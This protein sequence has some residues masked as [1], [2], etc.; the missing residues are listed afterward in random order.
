MMFS[1]HLN[2]V[3]FKTAIV[4]SVLNLSVVITLGTC[5]NAVRHWYMVSLSL[6]EL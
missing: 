1:M 3:V 2:Y 6:L 5:T 4:Y